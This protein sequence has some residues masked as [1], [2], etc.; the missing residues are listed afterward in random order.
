MSLKHHV[1]AATGLVVA[2]LTALTLFAGHSGAA[3]CPPAHGQGK[4]HH[5]AMS[6]EMH[7]LVLNGIMS[8]LEAT[9]EQAEKIQSLKKEVTEKVGAMAT[10]CQNAHALLLEEFAKDQPDVAR[11]HGLIDQE[12]AKKIAAVHELIDLMARLHDILSPAQRQKLVALV[13]EHLTAR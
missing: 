12:G 8:Y 11:I 1:V 3:G 10:G 7:T 5:P 4:W 13:Q 9:P 6:D 2:T